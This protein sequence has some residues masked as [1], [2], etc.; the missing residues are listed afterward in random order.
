[1]RGRAVVFLLL[2]SLVPLGFLQPAGVP[3]APKPVSLTAPDVPAWL[4]GDSWTYQTHAVA[5]DGPNRTS[6]WNNLTFV[7]SARIA[8]L[9]DGEFLYMYNSS[10]NG[11]LAVVGDILVPGT[12]STAHYWFTSSNVLGY[13]WK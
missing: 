7:V 5:R 11:D 9:Q 12:G 8:T 1:M 3:P 4:V 13:V 6:A 2:L 10:T